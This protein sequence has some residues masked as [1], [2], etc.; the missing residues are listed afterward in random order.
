MREEECEECRGEGIIFL[1]ANSPDTPLRGP[2]CWHCGGRGYVVISP[3]HIHVR[4]VAGPYGLYTEASCGPYT[5]TGDWAGDAI[6]E[7]LAKMPRAM[8]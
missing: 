3:R 6:S 5:G 7:V 1:N 2:E 8:R 4:E